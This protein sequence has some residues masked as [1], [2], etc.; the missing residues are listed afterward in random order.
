MG[1]APAMAGARE[2]TYTGTLANNRR[3][4]N[5]IGNSRNRRDVN[6]ISTICDINITI[7]VTTSQEKKAVVSYIMPV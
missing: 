1:G 7:W 3:Y 2:K 6:P 4:A 5:N